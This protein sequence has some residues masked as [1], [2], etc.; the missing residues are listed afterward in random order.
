MSLSKLTRHNSEKKRAAKASTLQRNN[1]SFPLH[2]TEKLREIYRSYVLPKDETGSWSR[3]LKYYQYYVREVLINPEYEI[4]GARGLLI[5]HTMGMGKTRLAIAIALSALSAQSTRQPILMLPRYLRKNFIDETKAAIVA[6]NPDADPTTLEKLQRDAIA[7]LKFVSSDAYNMADQVLRVA[8]SNSSQKSAPGFDTL[9]NKFLIID[10]AHGFFR[11]IINSATETTNARRLYDM[12]QEARNLRI[13]FLTGTVPSKDP[14]EL[15]PCF[16]ML[17]GTDILPALYDVFVQFYVNKTTHKVHNWARLANRL[18]GLVSH[19]SPFI[20]TIPQTNTS[21][22]KHKVTQME[23]KEEAK[24]KAK[25]EAKPAGQSSSAS[26][27]APRDDGYFPE[28]FPVII[29]RVEMA[30]DQYRQYLL[31]REKEESEGKGSGPRAGEGQNSSYRASAPP[32]ALP[33]SER[34]AMRSYYVRSRSLSNF[35]PVREF[36]ETPV[37]NMPDAA[38]TPDTSPKIDLLI[39]RLNDSPGPVLIYSQ[40]VDIGGLAVVGRFLRNAGFTEY[41]VP[42]IATFQKEGAKIGDEEMKTGGRPPAHGKRSG[43]GYNVILTYSDRPQEIIGEMR[44]PRKISE[45]DLIVQILHK[46]RKDATTLVKISL[47]LTWVA[48]RRAKA[49]DLPEYILRSNG[50]YYFNDNSGW[51]QLRDHYLQWL[52]TQTKEVSHG[53]ATALIDADNI[54]PAAI[55]TGGDKHPAVKM[56]YSHK[57]SYAIISGQ[58]DPRDREHIA[59]IFNSAANMYGKVI[60]AL[61]ISKTGAEGLNLKYIRQTHRLEPYWDKSREDQV[62]ARAV[63]PGSHDGLPRD[64]RDVQPYLY[65]AIANSPM[66]S[67]IPETNREVASIDEIFHTRALERHKLNLD[68]RRLLRAVSIECSLFGGP[69]C[70][71]CVPTNAPLFHADPAA[72]LRLPDPCAPLVPRDVAVKKIEI[73]REGKILTYYWTEAPS[74]PLGYQFY[75]HRADLGGYAVIDPSE[76]I[77]G[78]LLAALSSA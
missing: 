46:L 76:P 28:Q 1:T 72:D 53:G 11:A 16:N 59:T 7:K 75:E 70:H 50:K 66:W 33:G 36:Y 77:V 21:D 23:A 40:F 35:A 6:L 2:I 4:G 17:A 52:E 78:E 69:E 43:L 34:K 20:P 19:V 44:V 25:E 63:R 65:I 14:F 74:E 67:T 38:F 55:H 61:L 3:F 8:S 31:A 47:A 42:K 41:H 58:V 15:V 54:H 24:E 22:A 57:Y 10:E 29:E 73:N 56:Q 60:R 12:I 68:F 48:K 13:V 9:D 32:L 51:A 37:A 49:K 26:V 62:D 45:R 27:P 18:T 39:R 30:R 71:V 5:Y 64:Q